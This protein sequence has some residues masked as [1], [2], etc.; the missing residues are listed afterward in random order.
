MPIVFNAQAHAWMAYVSLLLAKFES[1]EFN[2][3]HTIMYKWLGRVYVI[4]HSEKCTRDKV[5]CDVS[6]A[7]TS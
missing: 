6:W 4:A 1:R 2:I 7:K 3:F 5:Q